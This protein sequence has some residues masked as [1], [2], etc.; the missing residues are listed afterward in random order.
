MDQ[1]I[2]Q[3]MLETALK[4]RIREVTEYQV[5]ISNYKLAIARIGDDSDMQ[6]FKALLEEL[7]RS[8][9]V[10]CRKAQ[11]MHDVIAEQVNPPSQ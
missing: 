10:E 6:E 2:R 9:I 3:E 4:G 11:L 1:Q 8:S 7:L 5:N